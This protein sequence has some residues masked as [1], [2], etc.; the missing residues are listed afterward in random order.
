MRNNYD[1]SNTKQA[2]YPLNC[3]HLRN[4]VI[5][6]FLLVFSRIHKS[7][8]N[9]QDHGIQLQSPTVQTNVTVLRTQLIQCLVQ[10]LT[11]ALKNGIQCIA[12]GMQSFCNVAKCSEWCFSNWCILPTK[13]NKPASPPQPHSQAKFADNNITLYISSLQLL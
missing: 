13:Q 10:H 3:S 6:P 1:F 7:C 9:T 11:T 5:C 12:I 8:C 4:K 2:Y